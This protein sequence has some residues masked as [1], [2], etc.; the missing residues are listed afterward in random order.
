[1]TIELFR[2]DLEERLAGFGGTTQ[3]EPSMFDGFLRGTAQYTMRGFAKT[4][5]AIDMAG[6]VFPIVQD[7]ITGGTE[8]RDRYFRE[9]DEVMGGAV[10]YWTPKPLEVGAAAEVVGSLVSQLPVIIASPHLAIGAQVL[11]TA[12]ELTAKGVAPGK[13]VT[14]GVVQGAGL[15][16]GIWMPVL[17]RTYL[18]RVLVGG[19]GF[20]L[21]QGVVTRGATQLVLEGTPAEKDFQALDQ[22]AMTL[23]VLLGL[24]FGNLVHLSAEQRAQGAAMW[25]RI[26]RW[27]EKAS[28]SERAAVATLRTAQHLNEDSLPG[29]AEAP[30]D[31]EAHVQRT[32]AAIDQLVRDKQVAVEDLPAAKVEADDARFK[33]AARR[34]EQ[35]RREGEALAKAYDLVIEEPIGPVNDPLVRLTPEEIGDVLV[36]RGPAF[37]KKGSAELNVGGFG[38][39]KFIWKH[40]AKSKVAPELQVTREDVIRAPEVMREYAPVI[41]R[42]IKGTDSGEITWQVQRA[43][44]KNLIYSVARY[45]DNAEQHVVSIFVNEGKTKKAREMPMSEKKNRPSDS[46][47]GASTA[48]P[49]DTGPGSFS[50]E[51]QGGQ[52]GGSNKSVRTEGPAGQ[53]SGAEPPPPR[54]AGAEKPAGP[55]AEGP[56]PLRAAALR[57]AAER[58]DLAIKVGVDAEGKAVTQSA[59]DFLD[60]ARQQADV[61]HQDAGLFEIAAQCLLGGA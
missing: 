2:Q 25:T 19:A 18:E 52:E 50:I 29:R 58:P 7:A 5:R 26:Q 42:P 8:A 34:A 35:I 14:A 28:P 49:G 53:P 3:L 13:A 9:H 60:Q 33:A 44:G 43:D 54:G 15:A 24:M 46:P 39:V 31:V 21:L 38:L 30:A 27:A 22:K 55:E 51:R 11:D 61:A 20:N 17:G 59:A 32:R 37:Y 57:I 48:R 1:M 4:A 23:D 12:E 41:D 56:D 6:A 10:D 40:G 16:A 45:A 47:G 36:E